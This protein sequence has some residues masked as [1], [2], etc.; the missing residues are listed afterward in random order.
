[1]VLFGIILDFRQ[2]SFAKTEEAKDVLA[3]DKHIIVGSVIP[4]NRKNLQKA[5]IVLAIIGTLIWGYGDI[6]FI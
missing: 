4:Q 1:M 5:A 3:N 2:Y 6:A